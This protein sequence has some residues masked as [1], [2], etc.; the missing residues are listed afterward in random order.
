[1]RQGMRNLQIELHEGKREFFSTRGRRGRG[2]TH[3]FGGGL[4]VFDFFSGTLV[5]FS[6]NV[7][8]DGATNNPARPTV[9]PSTI[10]PS[11]SLTQT[12]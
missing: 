12:A 4:K 5:L 2:A 3:G 1:M 7:P 10:S 6:A 11:P 8:C 9:R